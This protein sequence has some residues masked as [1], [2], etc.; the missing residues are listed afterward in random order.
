MKYIRED[1]EGI[2]V[3]ICTRNRPRDLV[4]CIEAV[5]RQSYVPDKF[6]ILIVDDGELSNS[7]I[8]QLRDMIKH[9]AVFRYHKKEKPGL[10]LSRIKAVSIAKYE[11]IL[12]LDD[13][14]EVEGA[15]LNT[16]SKT[17]NNY[18]HVLGIGGI[19]SLMSTPRKV[20]LLFNY[21]FL[22]N[23]GDPGKLSITGYSG[24]MVL[25]KAQRSIFQ[26]EFLSGCNMS[27]KKDA[28]RNLQVLPWLVGYSLGEDVYIS[29]VAAKNGNLLVNP[30]LKVKHHQ[31]SISRDKIETVAFTEVKNHH[32]LLKL[33]HATTFQH[34]AH[35]WTVIGMIIMA[36]I[37][38]N[39]LRLKGYLKGL[40]YLLFYS[41]NVD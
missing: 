8:D 10:L 19:D 28:L 20:G 5:I 14:V 40:I 31:S 37:K 32:C 41:N 7:F 33:K 34:L 22:Y 38:G 12:F 35:F 18:P 9:K 25:W 27:F 26:T 1:C 24:S 36:I 21:I 3:V 30:D 11:I 6:E 17:Y 13:D 15:Y 16:L 23:S 2:T 29:S 39:C 4:R